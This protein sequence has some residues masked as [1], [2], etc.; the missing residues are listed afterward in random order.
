M[1]E[2]SLNSQSVIT[3]CQTCNKEFST[4]VYRKWRE[5]VFKRDNYTCVFCKERGGRL[6]ADHIKPFAWF[7]ELRLVLSNGRTLCVKC[8]YKTPTYGG[9]N[10]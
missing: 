3:K 1:A 5:K 4:W 7:P 8:H 6:H 10:H 9:R 2:K